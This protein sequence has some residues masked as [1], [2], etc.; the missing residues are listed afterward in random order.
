MTQTTRTLLLTEQQAAEYLNVSPATLRD[1][2]YRGDGPR[3]VR[4]SAR[5]VRYAL[6][7]LDAWVTS[8]TVQSTSEEVAEPVYIGT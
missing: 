7:D 6:A 4:Y 5:C 3:H 8:R 2:R 1:W